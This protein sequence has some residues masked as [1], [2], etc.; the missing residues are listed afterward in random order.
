MPVYVGAQFLGGILG[1]VG[2]WIAYGS[3]A[4]EVT[5][6]ATTFPLDDVGDLR[7]LLV[8]ILIALILVF[9]VMSVATDE[10]VPAGVVHLSGGVLTI[11][12]YDSFI[13]E[14]ETPD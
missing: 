8:E 4:R 5:L 11:L 7:A 14:A 13:S 9:V 2:T 3:A 6:L 12:L 1:A 10:R